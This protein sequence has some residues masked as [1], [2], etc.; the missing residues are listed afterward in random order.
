MGAA[1][2]AGLAALGVTARAVGTRRRDLGPAFHDVAPELRAPL[3]VHGHGPTGE[4]QPITPETFRGMPRLATQG[5]IFPRRL[6]REQ[7]ID[8]GGRSLRLWLYETAARREGGPSGALIWIHG[9]GLIAGSPAQDHALCSRIARELG[10]LVVSVDYRLAPEHP[11][12]AA[13]DDARSALRW[14]RMSAPALDVDTSRVAVGGASAGGGLAAALAQRCRDE[15]V[16][17]VFQ[18]LIYPM[19]DDRT[20]VGGVGIPGRGDFVWTARQNAECWQAYLSHPPGEPE[21]RPWA[22]AARCEDLTG[23]APAWIGVGDLDLFV[24]ECVDYAGRLGASGVPARL[25]VEPGMYHGADICQWARSM[26]DFR[27]ES[28]D[29]LG[30]ALRRA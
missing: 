13:I 12:P 14:L 8:S 10:I 18:M 30:R 19:L 5:R 25:R 7:V 2:L 22:V 21:D 1:A 20:G 26:R 15:G 11:Y 3:L 23:L 24:D 29:A 28:I 17:L 9:G 16:G 6:G 27:A 4:P